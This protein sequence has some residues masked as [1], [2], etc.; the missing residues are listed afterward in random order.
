MDRT[1]LVSYIFYIF[2]MPWNT[3]WN[4]FRITTF[5]ESHGEAVGVVVDGC[6]AG[7]FL[8]E[9]DIQPNLDRRRPGQST[10][11]TARDEAD[12]VHIYSGI[13]EGKTTGAPIMLMV[14]NYD[15]RSEDYARIAEVYR[16]GHA[17]YTYQL[18]YGHRDPR[19]WGRTSARI[20]I[21]RVAAWAIAQKYLKEKYQ[22]EFLAYTES[23]GEIEADINPQAVTSEMVEANIVR[24]PDSEKAISMIHLIETIKSEGDSLGG[25][26]TAVIRACPAGLGNPEFDKFPALLAHAIMSINAVKWFEIGSGFSGTKMRWSE[27]NDL[28][29]TDTNGKIHTQTNNAGGVLWGITNGED[30][31]FRVAIKPTATIK[32]SQNTVNKQWKPTSIQWEGRHDP[33][34]IP[35]AIPIVEAMAA[36]VVMDYVLA[37]FE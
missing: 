20:M 36:L 14:T 15:Q 23:I 10:I 6:P 16:P 3:F 7:L 18:K 30:I 1:S 28:F 33:C 32:K 27:H 12:K 29:V 8:S 17:D 25:V 26:I 13:F 9:A 31:L 37:S 35:R 4:T 2:F 34:V 11:T 22:T 5:G 21:W 19:G 24:C